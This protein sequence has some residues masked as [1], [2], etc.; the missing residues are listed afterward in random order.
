[1][2]PINYIYYCITILYI[3]QV[4]FNIIIT[5]FVVGFGLVSKAGRYP[6]FALIARSN[7][8]REGGCQCVTA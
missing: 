3:S 1:M 4:K 5:K 7:Y 8:G 6:T 2:S